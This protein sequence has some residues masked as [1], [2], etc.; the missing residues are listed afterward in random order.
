M[1]DEIK[2]DS[3]IKP[4]LFLFNKSDLEGIKEIIE[5][6]TELQLFM[7]AEG[8]D[9]AVLHLGNAIKECELAKEIL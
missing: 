3:F 8:N 9:D 5:K 2:K 1:S 6:L 7:I 4:I